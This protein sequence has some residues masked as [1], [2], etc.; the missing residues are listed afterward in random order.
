M[1]PNITI[2]RL[3]DDD[4]P[5]PRCGQYFVMSEPGYRHSKPAKTLRCDSLSGS[6][7]QL[8]PPPV[9]SVRPIS[10]LLAPY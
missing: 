1:E 4:R 6:H 3:G 5:S 9:K 7:L 10:A 8:S 2:M